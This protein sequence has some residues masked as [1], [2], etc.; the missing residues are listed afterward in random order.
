[1]KLRLAFVAAALLACPLAV[2]ASIVTF[3]DVVNPGLN[4]IRTTPVTS[5][6]FVFSS[7]HYHIIDS[8]PAC[9]TGCVSNGT[10]YLAVD[11]P[12]LGFPVTMTHG[13]GLAF[14]LT[15]LDAARLFL[16][17]VTGFPNATTLDVAGTFMGGGS[18]AT[19]FALPGAG[20]GSF[21]FPATWVNLSSVVFSGSIPGGSTN[22]SWA[23]D[24]IN[25]SAVPEPSTLLLMGLG[26]VAVRH[27]RRSA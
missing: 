27:L 12:T 14:A 13:G 6:G 20:F 19:S 3:D 5:V 9:S 26:L 24:N 23:V 11:G 18:I 1:M 7:A 17:T 21:L 16:G 15:G 8:P 2:H 22:A 10:Q 25:A 4:A